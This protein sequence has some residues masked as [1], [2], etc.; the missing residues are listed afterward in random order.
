MDGRA[1]LDRVEKYDRAFLRQPHATVRGGIA[2]QITG[3]HSRRAVEPHEI[4]HRGRDEFSAA[5]HAHVRIGVRHHRASARVHDLAVERREMFSLLLGDLERAGFREMSGAPARDRA[6]QHDAAPSDQIRRLLLQIDL[7]R[8]TGIRSSH[9]CAGGQ[10]RQPKD[11]SPPSHARSLDGDVP[12][13]FELAE[14]APKC[15]LK[16]ATGF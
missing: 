10:Q 1:D 6:G 15:R 3:M 4:A 12:K 2:R 16:P 8:I 9:V 7:N 11:P 14:G 13:K 5:R